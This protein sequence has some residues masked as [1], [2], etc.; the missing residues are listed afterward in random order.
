MNKNSLVVTFLALCLSPWVAAETVKLRCVYTESSYD[1]SFMSQSESRSCPESLCYYDIRFDMEGGTGFING[2]GGHAVNITN[3][4]YVLT[5][6]VKNGIVKGIDTSFITIERESL[7]FKIKKTTPP[8]V[9]V[10]ATGSCSLM[11]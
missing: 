7:K 1:A 3:D 8:S 11:S 6:S 4:S 2:S 5:R 9:S 10:T